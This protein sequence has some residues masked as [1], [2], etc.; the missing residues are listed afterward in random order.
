M[1]WKLFVGL[2]YLRRRSKERFISAIS[3]ISILGVI[4]GVAALVV[5]ISIMTGFDV[6][7]KEKIIGT[8]SHIIVLKEGGI[9]NAEKVMNTLNGTTHV[10]ASSPFIDEQAF[11]KH[12]DNIVG[13]LLRG[14]DEKR[15]G[16]VS[17]VREYIDSGELS[18]GK[19]GI[20]IGRELAKALRLEKG[21]AITLFSPYVNEKKE[22]IVSGTFASGRYDYDA[23][24]VFTS[25]A[26][27][28]ALFKRDSVSGIGVKVDNEFN[29][30]T[31]KREL[32]R[33]FRYPFMI[34]T[35]MELDKNLMRALAIE[36]KMM[37]IILALI[38]VVA[39]FNIAS[40]LIMQVLEKT[41]DIG[42]LRA[43]GARGSD[44]KVIF[45][46]LG[47][48]VGALGAFLGSALGILIAGNINAIAGTIEK[49]TGLELFP[50][51]IYYLSSIPV[52]IVTGDVAV[53]AALSLALAVAASLYPAWKAS[54]LNP[55][56]AIRYG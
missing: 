15:E 46:F 12:K 29:A 54:R 27:A 23:N 19:N 8:Y 24:I 43:I 56:E 40:S 6:E 52:K 13:V 48:S 1:N 32:Q 47:F 17:N 39:C 45:I 7:I 36:K 18:F 33:V 20:I 26:E 38:I 16:A 9:A 10:V 44:I 11:L 21:D 50:S 30:Y 31:I 28:K 42:I 25:I 35:W 51:D 37:F 55:V 22:F 34:K 2:R 14:L 49:L 53:I 3:A 5:V 41:K 4:V